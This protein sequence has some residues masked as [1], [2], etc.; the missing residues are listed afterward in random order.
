MPVAC[1]ACGQAYIATVGR[2]PAK[3]HYC[4]KEAVW[5]AS[6]CV[7]CG[8]LVPMVGGQFS[9]G[10]M[11]LRCPKCGGSRFTTEVS[12]DGLEEP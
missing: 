1:A 12:P 8:A 10:Q 6:Q 3:C 11:E 2:Q 9:E 5:R 7:Q 4:G